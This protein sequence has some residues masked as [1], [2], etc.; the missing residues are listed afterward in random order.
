MS[1]PKQSEYQSEFRRE[2]SPSFQR[3]APEGQD[4]GVHHEE[5]QEIENHQ[6]VDDKRSTF[7]I[8]VN[9]FSNAEVEVEK[10]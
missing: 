3:H 4:D 2:Q 6:N 7:E 5:D 10:I 8:K 1:S 9:E